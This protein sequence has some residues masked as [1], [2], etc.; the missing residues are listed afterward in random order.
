VIP[1][2]GTG[3]SAVSEPAEIR[4]PNIAV[5]RVKERPGFPIRNKFECSKKQIRNGSRLGHCSLGNSSLVSNFV[6]RTSIL[7]SCLR[8]GGLSA[9]PG[10]FVKGEFLL[11]LAPEKQEID[12]GL[13]QDADDR[14]VPDMFD[15]KTRHAR[16]QRCRQGKEN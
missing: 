10:R 15:L 12:A 7:H 9:Q 6:L 13:K 5:T 3:V 11:K 1:G 2:D 14:Q 16:K 4:N 8:H